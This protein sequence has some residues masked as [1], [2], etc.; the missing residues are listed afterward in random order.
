MTPPPDLPSLDSPGKDALIVALIGRIDALVA[1][2]TTLRTR[3]TELEAKTWPSHALGKTGRK[4]NSI[5][6]STAVPVGE[7]SRNSQLL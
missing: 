2:N 7:G 6:V 4:A 3:V 5:S 1:E